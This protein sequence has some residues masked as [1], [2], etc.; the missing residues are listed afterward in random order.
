[1]CAYYIGIWFIL[2]CWLVWLWSF[3]TLSTIYTYIHISKWLLTN[4][5]SQKIN[6]RR[7]LEKKKENL[8]NLLCGY[9]VNRK[10]EHT[11]HQTRFQFFSWRTY[12]KNRKTPEKTQNTEKTTKIVV[13]LVFV[14]ASQ[15]IV[16][17]YIHI[18]LLWLYDTIYI[19]I[20]HV[21]L[22]MYCTCYI[23][24]VVCIYIFLGIRL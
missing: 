22:Y 23:M 3:Y 6:Y 12:G 24:W 5:S 9:I 19:Y 21:Q 18:N 15:V 2:F 16:Y 11:P 17:L 13:L 7:K 8:W 10:T 14:M 4:I 20:V 1:M